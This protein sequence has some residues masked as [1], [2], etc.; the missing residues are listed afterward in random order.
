LS[1]SVY[2]VQGMTCQ[3]CVDAVT[4]KVS[5]LA[6]VTHVDVDLASGR[7]R[8]ISDEPLDDDAVRTAVAEARY[9][10]VS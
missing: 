10:V 4:S 2:T 5:S 7:V 9:E 3:H 1:Q 6:T 8:V